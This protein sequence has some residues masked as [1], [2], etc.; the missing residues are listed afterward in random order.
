LNPARRHALLR[1]ER[2]YISDGVLTE[3][4]LED[5]ALVRFNVCGR[6]LALPTIASGTAISAENALD[7]A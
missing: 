3:N 4:A 7:D 2:S 1:E 5:A 6:A